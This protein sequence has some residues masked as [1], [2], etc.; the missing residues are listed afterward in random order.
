MTVRLIE[1]TSPKMARVDDSWNFP[2]VK[3]CPFKHGMMFSGRHGGDHFI[4]HSVDPE[5]GRKAICVH[6]N[7][8]VTDVNITHD[9]T[10]GISAWEADRLERGLKPG[11]ND[12]DWRRSS[13]LSGKVHSLKGEKYPQALTTENITVLK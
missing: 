13:R 4:A 3:N 10:M 5:T 2:S 9:R 7:T 11:D 1:N 6:I 12:K 8:D